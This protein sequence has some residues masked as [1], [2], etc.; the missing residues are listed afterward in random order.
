MGVGLRVGVGVGVRVGAKSVLG[1]GARTIVLSS[2]KRI[3]PRAERVV[4]RR[5]PKLGAA[6]GTGKTSGKATL[7]KFTLLSNRA[8][9]ISKMTNRWDAKRNGKTPVP[10]LAMELRIYLSGTQS[11][12]LAQRTDKNPCHGPSPVSPAGEKSAGISIRSSLLQRID[13]WMSQILA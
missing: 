11:F 9:S 6:V 10:T 7:W 4:D 12:T 8:E 1:T 5:A 2:W 3:P 13:R